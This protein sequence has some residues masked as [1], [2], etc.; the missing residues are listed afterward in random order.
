MSVPT[1]IALIL[2]LAVS[3]CNNARHTRKTPEA[4]SKGWDAAL[5]RIATL[6]VLNIKNSADTLHV[7][8]THFDHIG[9]RA[10]LHAAELIAET[11]QPHI[12]S[13]KRV[14]VMGDFNAEP[15][16]APARH[17]QQVLTDAC[18]AEQSASGTFNGFELNRSQYPRI[19]YIWY[20]PRDWKKIRYEVPQPKTGGRQVS[21][22][23]PVL[24]EFEQ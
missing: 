22:H 24:A 18:P 3:A 7:I 5:P 21:D 19:D 2:L 10:R 14:L 9:K 15:A 8:N 12:K 13:G 16:D 4:P 11:L 1:K 17:L 20:A 23:F 6:V